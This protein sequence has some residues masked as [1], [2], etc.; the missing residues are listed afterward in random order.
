MRIA[1]VC[2]YSW[3]SPGGVQSHVRGLAR[4]LTDAGLAV[5]V[6]A[7]AD[8]PV[9]PG[10]VRAVGRTVPV[11]DNGSVVPVALAP[12][13][14][15]RTARAVRDGGF[16]VVHVHE[17]VIPA[18]GLTAVL[19]AGD[20]ALVGTFHRY[21]E[22][23][24]WYR[25]FG[26][27]CRAVLGRLDAR[28]A[29]SEAARRHV[30]ATCPGEYLVIPNGIDA[31]AQPRGRR[32][33]DGR[34][35]RLVFVGRPDARKGLG[36]L[37]D[38]FARL[39][40][41]PTLDLVGVE[42]AAVPARALDGA[43]GRVRAHGVVSDARRDALL[44]RADVLCLPALSG[45]S[46]G[47]VAAEAMAA[48]LPVVATRVGGLPEL[49]RPGTGALVPPGDPAATA[50]AIQR[51]LSRPEDRLR[52]GRAARRRALELDWSRVAA[53]LLD[54]YAEALARRMARAAGARP[55]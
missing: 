27:L 1:L 30:A 7:P 40:G 28:V 14:V 41:R 29:V 24:G 19:A 26:A 50:A 39:P 52:A 53:R 44:R 42:A 47:I 54:V 34:A 2:P 4:A 11:R 3:T 32:D 23:P 38:A 35:G 9:E 25:V 55:G 16:D 22:R 33:D 48:G 43:R 20:A 18:V 49:V 8:G 21:A 6:V 45:E 17:P 13:A 46:F 10:L 36:V 15:R 37:L 31:G 5:R 12:A 51:L